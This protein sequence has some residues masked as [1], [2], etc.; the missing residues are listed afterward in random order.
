M[1]KRIQLIAFI[2]TGI[3]LIVQRP[4]KA[5]SA[6][7]LIQS[8]KLAYDRGQFQAA[9]TQWQQATAL[10]QKAQNP[11]GIAG[12]QLNQAQAFTA[13]GMHRRAC[14]TLITTLQLPTQ[15]SKQLCE[16]DFT[17][18]P[19]PESPLQSPQVRTMALH[20]LGETLR[21]IGNLERSQQ[22]LLNVRQDASSTDR[23]LNSSILL[24]LGNTARDLG[25]RERN[26]TN[27]L[28]YKAS[29]FSPKGKACTTSAVELSSAI[30]AYQAAID[31]YKQV[32]QTAAFPI[33]TLQARLNHLSLTLETAQWLKQN[34][35]LGPSQEWLK[36]SE[37]P[38]L[39][40]Q[41]RQ[42]LADLP[43]THEV[44]YARVNFARSLVQWAI[45]TGSTAEYGEAQNILN[46][47]LDLANQNNNDNIS[48]HVNGS[49]GWLYEQQQDWRKALQYTQQALQ[50]NPQASP[51]VSYQWKWQQGRI[52]RQKSDTAGAIA[53]YEDAVRL[54]ESA[55]QDVQSVNPDAQF[56]L[57]DNVEPVYRELISLQ[58]QSTNP[59]YESII[60]RIDALQLAE[61]ENFLRCKLNVSQSTSASNIARDQSAA[62]FYPVI[63]DDRLEVI[64]SLPNQTFHRHTVSIKRTDLEKQLQSTTDA[65]RRPEA[66]GDDYEALVELLHQQLIQPAQSILQSSGAKTLVF[67]LDG[68]LRQIPMATLKDAKSQ[69]YLIDQYPVAITPGLNVLGAKS[70]PRNQLKALIGGLTTETQAPVTIKG[71]TFTFSESLEAVRPEV[72]AIKAALPQ[73]KTLIDRDFNP[74]NLKQELQSATYPII[75]LATHG[76]FSSDP[77]Q[78]FIL[79]S[80]SQ[81]VSVNAFQEILN[82]REPGQNRQLD[83]LVFSACQTAAGDRRA[84]LGM[85]GAAI[86]A[87]ASSTIASLWSVDDTATQKIMTA[88]YQNLTQHPTWTKAEALQK[89]QQSVKQTPDF[90]HPVYWAAFTL[91]GNWR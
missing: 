28:A 66:R 36:T 60:K 74:N 2:T 51:D 58:L 82:Q 84:T 56:A 23:Y 86:R 72:I 75:H 48:I 41:V 14:K 57:R 31:C 65:L 5:E 16:V 33:T 50:K 55:R 42:E 63:L 61:L 11:T 4:V 22:V 45:L 39:L 32:A 10:Y 13:M 52:L 71:K 73:S 8:G 54:L 89:A 91:V 64:V 43:F 34:N 35:Q 78:T 17:T 3:S 37:V 76:K 44:G 9:L 83:L 77:Q 26:R 88:F 46:S 81:V 40:Q 19:L 29:S 15:Q 21:L 53:A 68:E 80:D 18:D 62:I 1:Q 67:V 38:Q 59:D 20:Q 7:D 24:S 49:L 90:N 27:E 47:T 6:A 87:G 85:A 79:T 69:Q 12:S 25:N 30:E 70:Y